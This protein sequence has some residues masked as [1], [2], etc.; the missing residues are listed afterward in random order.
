M[1]VADLDLECIILPCIP[2]FKQ[3][4]MVKFAK[5]ERVKEKRGI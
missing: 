5:P 2:A 4:Y 1:V 3:L